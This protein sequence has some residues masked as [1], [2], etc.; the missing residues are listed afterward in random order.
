MALSGTLTG[1]CTA[2]NGASS[3][4]DYKIEWSAT[5]NV[6]ANTSTIT[7]TAYVRSNNS[8]YSTSTNW[9]SII[10]GSTVKTFTYHVQASAGWVNF[11]SK[12]WTVNHNADGTCT[13]SISGSFSGTYNGNYVLRSGSVSGNITLNTIPRASSFSLNRTSATIGTDAITV[14]ISR[15]SSSFTHTVIYKFG[16]I[17]ADQATKT[18]ATSV[19]FTPV[20]SDCSQIPN[21]T[22]GTATVVV[23]TYN[24]ST[25]VGTASKTITLNVPSNVV[26]SIGS[27]TATGNNLLGSV[28]VAGKSTVTAKINSVSGSQGSTI[29]SYHLSG[30]G[31]N[32][33]SSSATSGVLSAG[34]HTITGKVTDSRGRTASKSTNITV[35]SYASPTIS[36]SVYRCNSNGTATDDGTFVRANITANVDNVGNA[37]VNAKQ[38]KIEWKTSQGSDWSTYLDWTNLSTY[39]ATWVHDLGGNWANTTSY[40]V[41]ISV[42][43]SYGTVSAT[44]SIGTVACVLN[45]EETGVGVGK[46]H[47]RG[48]L[49]VGGQLH[50]THGIYAGN[51][52]FIKTDP[53]SKVRFGYE[54]DSTDAFISNTA[55]N[56]LRLKADKTMTYAGYKVY[57]S[58]QKPTASEVGAVGSDNPSITGNLIQSLSGTDY[59]A[60]HHIGSDGALIFTTNS[61]G[62]SWDWNKSMSLFRDGQF[63]L[64]NH[65][66]FNGSTE[67][68]IILSGINKGLYLN[69]GSFGFYDWA[70]SKSLLR[71]DLS[72]Y[73]VRSD[74]GYFVTGGNRMI[75]SKS[76]TGYI[77]WNNSTDWKYSLF[78]Q[79][80]TSN[81]AA[82]SSLTN[83]APA[84]K[85]YSGT[86]GGLWLFP[87]GDSTG[88]M[89]VAKG[90]GWGSYGDVT[91]NKSYAMSDER[92]KKNIT[93]LDAVPMTISSEYRETG[94]ST[95]SIALDIIKGAKAYAYDHVYD[96]ESL[97]KSF[98]LMAQDLP[99]ELTKQFIRNEENPDDMVATTKLTMS[100]RNSQKEDIAVDIY[101]VSAIAWEGVRVLTERVEALEDALAEETA[102]RQALEERLSK[103]EEA[104]SSLK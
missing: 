59:K 56:F 86:G 79:T 76:S 37:N 52:V 53:N 73:E 89:V 92:L 72:N 26:P 8:N 33:S 99:V 58:Y 29:K 94:K 45:V 23:D 27:V 40:D 74:S 84:M 2:N 38:Y 4:Y 78:C 28:Y 54:A 61:S 77:S 104:F 34:T 60:I 57:T 39:S 100:A 47:E 64:K 103:L 98:G 101:G 96:D 90:T 70:N 62:L 36:A 69:N 5:Q 19:T 13:T 80:N 81:N 50:T 71:L 87:A 14:N 97:P 11:G 83:G 91:C 55:G 42:K 44:R 31:L 68:R 75:T 16:S 48:A 12:T 43:D 82:A 35:Y 41:R 24:G 17:S 66:L 51:S 3:R 65:L 21:A 88:G 93:P 32:N 46:I 10:N 67:R 63:Q 9:T 6:T 102:K 30:A 95:G 25:K 85:L 7:A 22:S 1:S 18:S 15:A 49:D 20:L